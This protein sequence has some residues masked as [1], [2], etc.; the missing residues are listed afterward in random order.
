MRERHF[1]AKEVG[2]KRRERSLTSRHLLPKNH[3]L[4]S[5]NS[6]PEPVSAAATGECDMNDRRNVIDT[7][8]HFIHHHFIWFLIGSYAVAELPS[9]STCRMP[10]DDTSTNRPTI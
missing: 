4:G 5:R 6:R 2:I 1:R 3:A 7:V 9:Q 8:S 10:K